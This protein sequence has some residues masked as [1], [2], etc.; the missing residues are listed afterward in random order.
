MNFENNLVSQIK[1]PGNPVFVKEKALNLYNKAHDNEEINEFYVLDSKGVPCGIITRAHL[2]SKFGGLYGY[3]LTSRMC[4]EE[5]MS[6]HFISVDYSTSVVD[7]AQKA[8]D[9][10]A[11]HVY[12]AIAVT[13][14]D[15]YIGEITIRDLLLALV[16][17][18]VESAS[19]MNPLTLL[20]GNRAIT[21]KILEMFNAGNGWTI[22][23]MDLDNFK[24][25][26]DAYGF[27]LGDQII[28]SAAAS[29]KV[30]FQK[31]TFLGH[32]GG[33]DFVVITEQRDIV[34]ECRKLCN[35]FRQ[36]ILPCYSEA[37]RERG[38]IVS[39]DRSGIVKK[40]PIITL[41]IAVLSTAYI[42]PANTDEFSEIIA[43]TKKLAKQKPG[44]SIVVA[45][46][47]VTFDVN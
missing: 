40:F 31:G 23:Y 36:M 29:M 30:C 45:R 28:M 7:I 42:H 34:D 27:T 11:N 22:A 15:I 17:V 3:E 14:D 44:N 10:P 20:P 13:K 18:K 37:D 9:R 35:T 33:D 38:Y 25:Y 6:S 47:K 8:M 26:N 32:I 41:S 16:K 1:M 46:Q 24:A 5:I 43:K 4:A 21:K 39:H 19:D 12:D 2:A